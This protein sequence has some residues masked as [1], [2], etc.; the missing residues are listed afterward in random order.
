MPL[1]F[2]KDRIKRANALLQA[3]LGLWPIFSS[4][5]IAGLGIDYN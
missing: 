1:A 4:F 5:A 3:G 2:G